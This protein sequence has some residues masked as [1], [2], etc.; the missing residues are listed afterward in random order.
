MIA[1]LGMSAKL[2]NMEYATRW[3]T[4]SSETRAQVEAEVQRTVNEA[5]ERTK[6]LLLDHRKELDLLAQALVKYETLSKEEVEKVIRGEPLPDRIPVPKGP[7]VVPASAKGP[8]PSDFPPQAPAPGNDG[9]R[10]PP[11][12]PPPAPSSPATSASEKKT[13]EIGEDENC[14]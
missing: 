2:G 7:M 10:P 6:Q 3:D 11:P 8:K 1:R 4:L 12:A 14:R 13:G 5:Y 9:Q